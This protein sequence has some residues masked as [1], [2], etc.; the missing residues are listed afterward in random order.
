[1]SY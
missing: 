1:G